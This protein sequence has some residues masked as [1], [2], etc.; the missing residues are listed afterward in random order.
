[1]HPEWRR[2]C[3]EFMDATSYS[4]EEVEEA[5]SDRHYDRANR[6]ETY[7]TY[8]DCLARVELGEPEFPESP[9][10]WRVLEER[11]SKRNFLPEPLG[12]NELNLL[13]WSCQ[14]VTA[15]MG[16]YQLRTAPSAGALYP[17]ETYL[18]VNEVDSLDPGLYH[19]DVRHWA[20]EALRLED[21]RETGC[22]ALYDQHMTS[23]A[24]VNF[25]WTAVIERCRAK[26][27][28]RAYRYVW[29]D[30]AHVA[31]NLLLAATALGL[32]ATVMG[33]WHDSLVHELLGIDGRSHFSALTATAGRIQG[34]DWLADRR[35][36]PKEA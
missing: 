36:P 21:L 13:L 27:Y 35:A 31:E 15:D 20:L 29:W 12:L 1:M 19:L 16:G 25:I 32:G 2:I 10:F 17:I 24:P 18:I 22:R 6:P 26:Y 30:S 34:G 23:L 5:W 33:A 14:G 9:P 11:R 4:P 8:P 28:E 3:D 7:L